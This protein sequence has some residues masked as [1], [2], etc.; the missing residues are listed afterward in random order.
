MKKKFKLLATIA[1]I[2]MTLAL[3]V[4]GVLA[5]TSVNVTINSNVSYTAEGVAFKLHGKSEL[6][7]AKPEGVAT[8]LVEGAQGVETL[9]VDVT[10]G[11]TGQMT[12]DSQTYTASSTWVVYT[13]TVENIGSNTIDAIEVSAIA[14]DSNVTATSDTPVGGLDQGESETFRCYFELQNTNRSIAENATSVE[15]KIGEGL[16]LPDIETTY[17][18]EG[19]F[20]GYPIY[21]LTNIPSSATVLEIRWR[22][23]G[24]ELGII[25]PD[26]LAGGRVEFDTG[27][28]LTTMEITGSTMEIDVADLTEGDSVATEAFV[29]VPLVNGAEY[30]S[31]VSFRIGDGTNYTAWSSTYSSFSYT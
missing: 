22:K 11:A 28:R 31:E 18:P 27:Y 19:G 3:M 1:S 10:S 12:L 9:T 7:S 4:F 29:A 13:F 24:W 26:N 17:Y 23:N 21:T 30:Y 2:S 15:I 5:A 25:D 14:A 20:L 8:D 6:L 16:K